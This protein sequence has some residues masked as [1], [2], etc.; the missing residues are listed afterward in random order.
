[1]AL[2]A[3][4]MLRRSHGCGDQMMAHTRKVFR[5]HASRDAM[6][7]R[8]LLTDIVV[9]LRMYTSAEVVVQCLLAGKGL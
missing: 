8:E 3:T 2:V 7:V 6:H 4:M 1:M 9:C 5:G